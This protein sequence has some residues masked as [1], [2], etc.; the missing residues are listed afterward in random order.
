MLLLPKYSGT[1][2]LMLNILCTNPIQSPITPPSTSPLITSIS[3]RTNQHHAHAKQIS[4]CTSPI[5]S[6]VHHTE[7]NPLSLFQKHRSQQGDET[8]TNHMTLAS[9][10]PSPILTTYTSFSQSIKERR[11]TGLRMN[12]SQEKSCLETSVRPS[13]ECL[14]PHPARDWTQRRCHVEGMWGYK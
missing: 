9:P 14:T 11:Q 6:L 4:P 7:S 8:S 10:S 5:S 13:F 12:R 2:D 3:T 1:L